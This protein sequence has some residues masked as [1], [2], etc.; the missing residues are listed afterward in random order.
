VQVSPLNRC[1]Q[2]A[3]AL[4]SER[5]DL[6]YVTDLRLREMDFGIWE[7]VAWSDIPRAAIDT[8]TID[9]AEH[10]FGGKESANEVLTRVANAWDALHPVHDTL[11]IAHAGI[12][13]AATLLHHGI[14]HIG[15]AEDW[16]LAKLP[17]GGWVRL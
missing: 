14:R 11:W 10:R 5:N 8:W 7:G 12:A 13:Q 2:L 9:F 6:Q 3:Q 4:Q 15:R 17:Y 16:P 1:Q